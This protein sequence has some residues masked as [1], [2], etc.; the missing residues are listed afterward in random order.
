MFLRIDFREFEYTA[1][2]I[3]QKKK[4]KKKQKTKKAPQLGG[5]AA[6]QNQLNCN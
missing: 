1:E 2:F 6:G 3:R 5:A 4:T